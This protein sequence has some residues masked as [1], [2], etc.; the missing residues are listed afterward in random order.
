MSERPLNANYQLYPDVTLGADYQIGYGAEIG[1]APSPDIPPLTIGSH[2]TI[3]SHSVLYAGSVIG[4][5]FNAGHG[6]LIREYAAIGHHVSIG[7]HSVIE[8]HVT[9]GDHV[10]IHSNSFIPEYTVIG[11]HAWIGPC[12][13]IT[14]ARYPAAKRT[15]ELLTPV[16]IEAYARIGANV[17]LLPGVR[18]GEGALIG[19]GSVVTQ[20]VAAHAVV[21]GN[22]MKTLG[23]TGDLQYRDGSKIYEN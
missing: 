19:A 22:P 15:K 8:H 2:A 3:R 20:D 10:R 21:A 6:A 23:K 13:C 18:I 5:Y 12:V 4:D 9:L 11:A 17:T 7:S 16:I 1:L 14:N